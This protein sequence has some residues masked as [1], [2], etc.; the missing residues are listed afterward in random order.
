LQKTQSTGHARRGHGARPA[1][2]GSRIAREMNI[3]DLKTF[4]VVCDTG[5]LSAAAA[6]FDVPVSTI[7]R[8]L[9]KLEAQLGHP[10]V[11]R[12]GRGIRLSERAST[13]LAVIRETLREL[14]EG[15]DRFRDTSARLLDRLRI[16]VPL[17]AALSLM[18]DVLARARQEAPDLTFEM[19]AERRNVAVLE[20]NYDL[21]IRLGERWP[22]DLIVQP[23]GAV[24]LHL[25][26]SRAYLERRPPPSHPRELALHDAVSVQGAPHTLSFAAASG[27]EATGTL[28]SSIVVTTF[29]EA[30]RLAALGAGIVL[31]PSYTRR[32]LA[33][34]LDLVP[35][36]AGFTLPAPRLSALY[37]R[38]NRGADAISLVCEHVRDV[39]RDAEAMCSARPRATRR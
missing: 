5:S 24:S 11:E 22:G 26:A 16:S 30:A 25:L 14:E 21:A 18:P 27:R 20:E 12:T 34:S 10:L 9:A 1:T 33:P 2:T 19:I 17:E 23:L 31:L 7:S 32:A 39:L 38:R 36:L 35:I 15:I 6:R 13:F 28:R 3:D 8:R 37:P 4:V 29:T